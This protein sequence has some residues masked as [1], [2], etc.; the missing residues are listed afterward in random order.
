MRCIQ[1]PQ[2]RRYAVLFFSLLLPLVT[3]EFAA[4][5]QAQA[6]E[7]HWQPGF[8]PMQDGVQLAYLPDKPAKE[9]RFPVLVTYDGYSGGGTSLRQEEL[10]L[11]GHGYA[12]LGVSVRG[13]GASGGVFPGPFTKQEG[14]D[15]KAVIEWVGVQ[16]WCDGDVGMYGTLYA[17]ISQFEVAAQRPRYLKALAA[18]SVWGDTYEG[19]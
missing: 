14:E 12:V 17:G 13:T 4:S 11:L 15:G 19:R 9:G 7:A 8:I 6:P 10:D 18:G 3:L 16:P 2:L 5:Q 1:A